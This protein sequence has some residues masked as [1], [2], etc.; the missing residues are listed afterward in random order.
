M[1]LKSQTPLLRGNISD[2]RIRWSFSISKLEMEHVS[3]LHDDELLITDEIDG[4]DVKI[5]LIGIA[6]RTSI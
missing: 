1:L 3:C 6:R 4:Y 5:V 2:L